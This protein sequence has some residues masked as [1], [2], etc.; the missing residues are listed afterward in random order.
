M[1]GMLQQTVMS[2]GY[3]PAAV[4]SIADRLSGHMAGLSSTILSNHNNTATEQPIY[5]PLYYDATT[6]PKHWGTADIKHI[7]RKHLTGPTVT[8]SYESLAALHKMGDTK[9]LTQLLSS[10]VKPP[11]PTEV[12]G[13]DYL[14]KHVN[15]VLDSP[16]MELQDRHGNLTALDA[17]LSTHSRT[18]ETRNVAFC[19]SPRGTGKSQFIKWLVFM[20][21]LDAMKCGRVIVRCCDK[22]AH[23]STDRKRPTW[24]AQVL[25]DRALTQARKFHAQQSDATSTAAGL[26][27]LI[28][29]HVEAVTGAS[30][31]LSHYCDPQTAYA[32]WM[33]E[34]TRH[35]KIPKD[36][37]NVDPLIILDT[38]EI[39]S[40]HDH[41]SLVHKHSGKPYT[42]LEAFCLAVPAPHSILAIGCNAQIDASDPQYSS[43]TNATN[44]GPLLPLSEQGGRKAHSESW[45]SNIDARMIVPLH[46][47]TGGVPRLLRLAHMKQPQTMSLASR[48]LN[49]FS[50][51]FE[52]Y[53][54]A[55]RSQ[56]PVQPAWLSQAYTCL[57]VSS[58]KAKVNGSDIIPVNPLWKDS[59]KSLTYAEATTMSM[60]SYD[61]NTKCFM[62]APITFGDIVVTK[63]NAP[64]LPSQLHPLLD[65]DV[66]ARC[67]MY[68]DAERAKLFMNSFLYA[69]YA[70]YLL[71]RWENNSSAWVSLA[72]VF[73][74]AV[75]SD[76]MSLLE[77]YEVNIA[78]GVRTDAK[79]QH[80]LSNE[81]TTMINTATCRGES[82]TLHCRD[83]RHKKV[84]FTAL[85]RSDGFVAHRVADRILLAERYQTVELAELACLDGN[86]KMK[87]II[88]VKSSAMCNVG[89][90]FPA[91]E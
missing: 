65:A 29:T 60:G 2:R 78:N 22:T 42:L 25:E 41:K 14:A 74:G 10:F 40:E 32:T 49:S 28:R 90:L 3:A 89:W 8:P 69:V 13:V 45:K 88:E 62:V 19:S 15:N 48:S 26:C 52:V 21:R 55:A 5:E 24:I 85:L 81:T 86:K 54:A 33:S 51:Y 56:Y 75:P 72:K 36:K 38:C 87:H 76:Q 80:R 11:A 57:L 39:L 46:N 6:W 30:Q 47:L 63:P 71:A 27:E 34:T 44:V 37:S 53:S 31:E 17:A 83:R 7:L 64:I 58:T 61:P 84:T 77:R 18:T 23:D 79:Q 43:Q 1:G 16:M 9:S 70:R 67:G 82:I 59:T 12:D 91:H 4:K 50:R 68:S 35:F 66:V 20:K 73:H